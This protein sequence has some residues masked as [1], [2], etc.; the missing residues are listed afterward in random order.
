M[1][2]T[3]RRDTTSTLWDGAIGIDALRSGSGGCSDGGCEGDD[4]GGDAK[5][6][7]ELVERVDGAVLG[8]RYI[9]LWNGIGRKRPDQR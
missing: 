7:F 8:S 9:V 4:E 6:H 1:L 5:L 3:G 2:Q